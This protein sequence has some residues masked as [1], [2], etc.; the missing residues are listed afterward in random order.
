MAGGGSRCCQG[1]GLQGTLG[2][3]SSL[4]R[5]RLAC[6]S[7]LRRACPHLLCFA[8]LLL[9]LTLLVCCAVLPRTLRGPSGTGFHCCPSPLTGPSPPLPLFPSP[10]VADG[11]HHGLPGTT[12]NCHV[13]GWLSGLCV[14]ASVDLAGVRL[15]I[16]VACSSSG[17]WVF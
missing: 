6:R 2:H 17:F 1:P 16:L 3:G 7:L 15:C 11:S 5:P 12:L 4:S 13:Q 10:P 14:W 9:L 8:L